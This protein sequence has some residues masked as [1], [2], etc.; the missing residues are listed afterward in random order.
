[1]HLLKH[2]TLA[3]IGIMMVAGVE[4]QQANDDA[5]QLRIAALEALISAPADRA[6]PIVTKVLNGDFSDDLKSRA[7]FVLSQIERPEAQQ[8]LVDMARNNPGPL[9]LEAIRMIGISGDPSALAA[10]T[11][12]YEKGDVAVRESVLE[13]YLVADDAESVYQIASRTTDE[14]EFE[15]AV[16]I[17]GAMDARDQLRRLRDKHGESESLIQAYSISGDVE[18]LRVL[19]LDNSNPERQEQA[20]HGLGVAGGSEANATLLE[21]Y[22]SSDSKAVKEAALQGMLIA[23]YDEGVLQL[24]RASQDNEEKRELLQTLVMMDSDAVTDIIDATFDG[25]R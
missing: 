1:M 13:A 22:R 4:A 8:L 17:L 12:I 21:V 18:S 16:N 11:D 25:P 15:R 6:L 5:E 23:D 14:R 7:L 24:F 10:L 20:L 9:R 3:A 2:I 19:A